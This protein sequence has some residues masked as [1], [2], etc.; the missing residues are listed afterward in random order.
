MYDYLFK[1]RY[2][3]SL[4]ILC[5]TIL[6]TFSGCKDSITD[7]PPDEK[8]P[9]YQEDIPWPSLAESPW[10]VINADMQRTG[11]SKYIGPQQ[12]T[13]YLTVPTHQI[14]TGIVFG[15]DSVFYF[16]TSA[17]GMDTTKLV[18]AK[19]DGTILW[20]LNLEA[21]ETTSTPII[22]DN[23]TIYIAN[24]SFKKIF[25]VNPNGTIKWTYKA[26][27]D[28]WNRG[29]GIGKDGTIYAIENGSTLIAL[30]REGNL[31]WKYQDVRF[32]W[33]TAVNISFSPDGNTLY[34]NGGGDPSDPISLIAF[35]LQSKLIKW[36]FG[37]KPLLNAP[38]VDSKGNI[39]VLVQDNLQNPRLGNFYCI[40][41]DGN[42][43]WQFSHSGQMYLSTDP[44]IDKEGNIYFA[45]D[46]LYSLSY[47]GE[48]RW[49]LYLNG[50][51][52]L[53]PLICDAQGTVYMAV[54][55]QT[56]FNDWKI[57]AVSGDGTVKW[58]I[59]VDDY[60]PGDCPAITRDG[61]LIYPP[62]RSNNLYIIK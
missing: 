22:D 10:P 60:F 9:G 53:A 11:R 34:I 41:P 16:G 42:I 56:Y 21:S 33:G 25:A 14:Q 62:F 37:Q 7:P 30:S 57:Y 61:T 49:K 31:L 27:R 48:L 36:T 15:S 45:M 8:P 39:Y 6:I 59:D 18:A 43:K 12:G 44:A 23:G 55:G 38:M 19:I 3:N 24:G 4:L 40:D 32:A 46:T 29:M 28:V 17:R 52:N 51:S 26:E 58:K 2:G 5:L 35:D 20:S 1:Y 50:Y 13:I 54:A 47:S